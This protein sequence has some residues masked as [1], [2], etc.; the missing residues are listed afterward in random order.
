MRGSSSGYLIRA[1]LNRARWRGAPLHFD[2]RMLPAPIVFLHDG[3]FLL[4]RDRRRR[5]PTALAA[6][7]VLAQMVER[8]VVLRREDLGRLR[9]VLPEVLG[10]AALS[11]GLIDRI[12]GEFE[13]KE[14]LKEK[15]GEDVEICW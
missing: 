6:L 10:E 9:P 5:M 1:M 4:G 13:A 8:R 3:P 15:I 14:Y 11:N 12:G 7:G 2:M